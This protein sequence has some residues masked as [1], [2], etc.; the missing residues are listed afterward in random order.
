M[1]GAPL[2]RGGAA[3]GRNTVAGYRGSRS[4]F[5][6]T[7]QCHGP[8]GWAAL[9][10]RRNPVAQSQTSGPHF[11]RAFGKPGCWP[12]PGKWALISVSKGRS[13]RRTPCC[14]REDKGT[15][16]PAGRPFA[17]L[18]QTR[19]GT[20]GDLRPPYVRRRIACEQRGETSGRPAHWR[21][22]PSAGRL[23]GT[24][25]ACGA[26]A[27]RQQ[28]G[29]SHAWHSRLGDRHPDPDHHSALSF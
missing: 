2:G 13:P 21:G 20:S 12:G 18:N 28:K 9:A 4:R 6:R 23:S 15:W 22:G 26:L 8:S 14:M 29:G 19:S 3:D 7:G 25:A 24:A 5:G 27:L 17:A 16:P 10:R 1:G 11:W